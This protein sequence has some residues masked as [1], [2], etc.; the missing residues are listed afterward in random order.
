MN[1]LVRQFAAPLL[2]AAAITIA[3]LPA[4]AGSQPVGIAAD[5]AKLVDQWCSHCHLANGA[6]TAS[7][8]A[9]AFV[10]LM[11]DPSYTENRLRAWLSDPH[12]PMPKIDLTRQMIRD[13]IAYL[14]TLRR[15]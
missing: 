4:N 10:N 13:V 12:P 9:P 15:P 8:T 11:N 1:A 7:D 2:I 14:S 3:G 5:G 6:T